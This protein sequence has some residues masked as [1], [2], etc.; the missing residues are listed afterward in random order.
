MLDKLKIL[1]IEDSEN[2]ALLMKHSLK[3]ICKNIYHERVET[4]S[5]IIK[6]IKKQDWDII[7]IDNAL[8]QLTAKEVIELIKKKGIETPLISVSGS[9]M[10]NVK[11]QCLDAGAVAFILKD[12]LTEFAETIENILKQSFG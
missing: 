6:I 3:N 11:D 10:F 2:D 9:E 5:E 1:F 12:N 7:V 8:P 4:K